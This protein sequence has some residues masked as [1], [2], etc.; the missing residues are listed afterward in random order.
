MHTLKTGALIGAAVRLG[1]PC[2]RALSAAEIQALDRFVE[3]AGLAF[4]VV[5]DVLDVEGSADA[6]GKTP[7]KDAAQ[8]K[9]TFVRALGLDAAKAQAERLRTSAHA[10]LEPFGAAALRLRELSDWIVLR[11]R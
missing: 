9:A 11:S 2:G 7:G 6:L 1:A 5:D 4:Q 3:A 8:G 10:A